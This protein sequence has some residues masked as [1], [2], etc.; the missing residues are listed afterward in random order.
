[1]ALKY[2]LGLYASKVETKEGFTKRYEEVIRPDESLKEFYHSSLCW[3]MMKVDIGMITKESIPV[4]LNRMNVI[5]SSW[6][7]DRE[8]RLNLKMEEVLEKYFLGYTTNVRTLSTTDFI[9]KRARVLKN[10]LGQFTDKQIEKSEE[11][12]YE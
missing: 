2:G 7:R 11:E 8:E 12:E 3:M 4:F 9:Q 10:Q 1:M 5:S 6:V